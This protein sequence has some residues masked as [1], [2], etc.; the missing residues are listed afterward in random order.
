MEIGAAGAVAAAAMGGAPAVAVG[1]GAAGAA[2]AGVTT[3]AA[4]LPASN[5]AS[6]CFGSTRVMRCEYGLTTW[7]A[8]KNAS[9]PHFICSGERLRNSR[10]LTAVA[11]RTGL[12]KIDVY[13][14]MARAVEHTS[15]SFASFAGSFASSQGLCSSMY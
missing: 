7:P 1:V 2:D 15:C 14:N 3:D 9:C 12:N 13:Q 10:T 8:G 5:S 6:S 4:P 11:G